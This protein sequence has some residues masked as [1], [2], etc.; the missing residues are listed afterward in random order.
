MIKSTEAASV[1][2]VIPTFNRRV[3]LERAV[4]SVLDERRVPICLRVH[5][6]ASEDDTETYM[7]ELTA[8][9]KRVTYVR[10]STNLGPAANGTACF[11]G[12]QSEYFV[13]LADDD[14]L[15][16]EFLY[17]AYRIMEADQT[18]GAAAFYAE[19]R[20]QA[21]RIVNTWPNNVNAMV[22]GRRSPADHLR[23]WMLS[24]H[25][26]WQAVLWRSDGLSYLGS[27]YLHTGV[28]SDVDFQVQ[29]IAKYPAFVVKRPGAVFSVHDGQMS[30]GL[31]VLDVPSWAKLFA[32]LDRAVEQ[33]A[34]FPAD[35]YARL[36]SIMWHR[37]RPSW[38]RP[39]KS[40]MSLGTL[41]RIMICAG[42][43]LGD[44]D[45]AFHL[46]GELGKSG[47]VL[48]GVRDAGLFRLPPSRP[49]QAGETI[50]GGRL[51]LMVRTIQQ[52]KESL[53]R[54]QALT[55]QVHSLVSSMKVLQEAAL[56]VAAER[57]RLTAE[58]TSL[59]A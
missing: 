46:A 10:N 5:D 39:A 11:A 50:S 51:D 18:L 23:D 14:Y 52:L 26:A 53:E 8:A 56:T 48:G 22:E 49:G 38:L 17:D 24:S 33:F 42:Y 55:S 58:L 15:L 2:V 6:N 29:L 45:L 32:R 59:R 3:M 43:R 21:G 44:W 25:Y 28:P 30:H 54:E 4:R 9:D 12:V 37:M 41:A 13:M 34:L 7:R 47:E 20:D 57:N 19:A 16:P 35:E 31:G 40:P 1:T 27:P 36:R